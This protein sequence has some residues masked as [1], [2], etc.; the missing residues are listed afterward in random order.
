[1]QHGSPGILRNL[2]QRPLYC[3]GFGIPYFFSFYLVFGFLED[4]GYLPRLA[5]VLDNVFHRLGLHGYSSIPVMLGL[6]CKVPALLSTRILNNQRKN[7]H[8]CVI[9]MSA[10][11][12]A[13]N[14]YDCFAGNELWDLRC[15]LYIP[16]SPDSGFAT[17]V[18]IN[19]FCREPLKSFY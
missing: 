16:A 3:I 8:N 4:I 6:G 9:L 10:P 15:S 2:Y 12:L 11:C 14:G 19:K 5:V 13:P 1:M 17:N 7:T 18:G